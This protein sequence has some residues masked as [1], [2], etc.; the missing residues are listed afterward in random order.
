MK[1]TEIFDMVKD[2]LL[3]HQVGYGETISSLDI[4]AEAGITPEKIVKKECNKVTVGAARAWMEYQYM[5]LGEKVADELVV[6]LNEFGFAADKIHRA[7]H[8]EVAAHVKGCTVYTRWPW[9]VYYKG[10]K[11]AQIAEQ[12]ME[13]IH[14]STVDLEEFKTVALD[15][16]QRGSEFLDLKKERATE[17]AAANEEMWEKFNDF[18]EHLM[19]KKDELV[20]HFRGRQPKNYGNYKGDS[21]D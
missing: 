11:A 5:L 21:D 12:N 20:N 13:M 6:H 4:L 9:D 19:T 14:D 2:Y 18:H 8:H 1:K 10:R 15:V 17:F 16:Y 7:D 3:R